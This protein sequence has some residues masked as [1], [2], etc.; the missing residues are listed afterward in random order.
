[1]LEPFGG[2]VC[3][4]FE[5]AGFGEEVGG[6]GDDGEVFLCCH[7]VKRFLIPC[8]DGL[9]VSSGDAEGRRGDIFDHMVSEISSSA[10]G[11]DGFDFRILR[12]G[13][14]S[15]GSACAGAEVSHAQMLYGFFLLSP[16][17]S[18]GETIGEEGDVETVLG[19]H[20][21]QLAFFLCEEIEEEGG[22]MMLMHHAGDILVA[23]T[24]PAAAA[25]VGEEDESLGIDRD[26]QRSFQS[27]FRAGDLDFPGDEWRK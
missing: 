1:M 5:R 22:Q 10:T 20:A 8:Y 13:D 12:G 17:G 19:S 16:Q 15:G 18:L 2:L 24:E 6:A 4:S 27:D 26:T 9:V 23:W 25:P 14:E 21:I 3:H 11:N 7:L